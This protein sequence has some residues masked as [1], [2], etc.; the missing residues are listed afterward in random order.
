MPSSFERARKSLSRFRQFRRRS[1]RLR[2]SGDSS[3]VPSVVSPIVASRSNSSREEEDAL[4]IGDHDRGVTTSTKQYGCGSEINSRAAVVEAETDEEEEKAEIEPDVLSGVSNYHSAQSSEREDPTESTEGEASTHMTEDEDPP[5]VAVET[6]GEITSGSRPDT[7]ESAP[8]E[9]PN[10]GRIQRVNESDDDDENTPPNPNGELR[11]GD[12]VRVVNKRH[13]KFGYTGVV[14]HHTPCFVTFKRIKEGDN[15]ETVKIRKES[16]AFT[17]PGSFTED[18]PAESM[19]RSQYAQSRSGGTSNSHQSSSRSQPRVL[20]EPE[21]LSVRSTKN[22]FVASLP[23]Q[24]PTDFPLRSSVLVLAQTSVHKGKV[25]I[26]RR[27]TAKMCVVTF[28]DEPKEFRFKPQS[29]AHHAERPD[30]GRLSVAT[31]STITN[32]NSEYL[33]TGETRVDGNTE[34]HHDIAQRSMGFCDYPLEKLCLGN[35]TKGVVVESA[36][37]KIWGVGNYLPI[38]MPLDPSAID[39]LSLKG[40][41]GGKEFDLYYAEVSDDKSR[42]IITKGKKVLIKKKKVTAYYVHSDDLRVHEEML[43]DFGV[44]S[45]SKVWARRKHFLSPAIKHNKEY[46]LKTIVADNVAII[47]DMGTVGCGFISE[48]YLE[49]LLGNNADA[50]RSMAIQIRIFVPTLGVFKGMLVRK[51]GLTGHIIQLNESLR[52]VGP[53]L[54]PEASDSRFIVIKNKFPSRLNFEGVGRVFRNPDRPMTKAFVSGLKKGV[55]SELSDMHARVLCSLGASKDIIIS[56]KT[57]YQSSPERLCHAHVVGVADPTNKLP[58]NTVFISGT[59]AAEFEL[60]ELFVSRSPCMEVGDGRMVSVVR[61]RPDGMDEDKW[62]WLQGLAFGAIIFANPKRGQRPLPELIA[63]GDLDGD[64]Y[65]ICWEE[66][67]LSQI[68]PVPITDDELLSSSGAAVVRQKE[69]NPGW[70][71]DA[72]T[73]ISQIP[74]MHFDI[75]C[76]IGMLYNNSY[77]IE[78]V[79]D[80]NAVSFA[81]AYKKAIDQKK[82][83]ERIFLPRH[84]WEKL[85]A[86]L[87][88]YLVPE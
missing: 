59:M 76:L 70:Y 30:D 71:D 44:L 88:K 34:Q 17:S 2:G 23:T 26:V 21:N 40:S 54:S 15:G 46:A 61:T 31:M 67:I 32:S 45:P 18:Q 84:L 79:R 10:S 65:W 39:D 25:G 42:A 68:H 27:H 14:I 5:P 53:S 83:G 33:D 56:Y 86:N 4:N 55:H 9:L 66:T 24:R 80:S 52:K 63:G 41:F 38:E 64:L 28:K 35:R 74:A 82:N 36:F 29:L 8:L 81:R 19:P 62:E 3:S 58:P 47:E 87:H 85:P 37:Q 11:I 60:N 1:A 48:E 77:K 75:D 50:R 51:P 20:T 22:S 12:R 69:Y 73:F 78:D 13:T 57:Q 72:Q 16:V 7:N 43:A 49:H 6:D